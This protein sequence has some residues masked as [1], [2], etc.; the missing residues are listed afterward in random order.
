MPI[1]NLTDLTIRLKDEAGNVYKTFEPA[2][3]S[4]TIHARG[5][6]HDV[7]GVLVNVTVVTGVDGLPE[8]AEGMFYIVPQPVAYTHNRADFVTP[9]TGPT[10][11]LDEQQRV[12]AVRRL[13]SVSLEGASEPGAAPA[14]L[15]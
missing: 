12:Y 11:T 13:Y 10:A 1:V 8:P 9:D 6:E 2:E 7:D 15:A 5:Q 4:I 14:G 3:R